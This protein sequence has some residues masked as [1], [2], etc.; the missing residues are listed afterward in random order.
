MN[1]LFIKFSSDKGVW[2]FTNTH[3]TEIFEMLKGAFLINLP[4]LI[5]SKVHLTSRH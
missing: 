3:G 1:F 2:T 5:Y 4:L